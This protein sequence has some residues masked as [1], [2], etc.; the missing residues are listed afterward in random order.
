MK[1]KKVTI[2]E[3][4]VQVKK[5]MEEGGYSYNCI[6]LLYARYFRSI[7]IYYRKNGYVF[8]DPEV[9]E[10]YIKLQE[11]RQ[12]RGEIVAHYVHTIKL[13]A[14]R[15]NEYFLTGEI[16]ILNTERGSRYVVNE[17]NARLIDQFISWK[18]YGPN[19]SD[20]VIWVVRR[21]LYFFEKQ[22]HD[23]IDTVT[24]EEV[25]QYILKTAAEMKTSSLHNVLLYLKY[26]HIFLREEGIA[27][28]DCVDLLSY[29]VCREMPI[30]GYV[31][32]EELKAILDQVDLN[33]ARG[34]RDYAMI[35]LAATTGMRA[36]DIIRV[37][38][39][40]IDWRK[41]EIRFVQNKTGN[42]TYLPLIN[43][44]GKALQ[45]YILNARPS[46]ACPEIFLTNNP[47][48][49]AIMDASSVG[50]MFKRYQKKAGIRRTPFDGKGFHGLRRRLAKRLIES[51]TSLTTI[52]QILG[53]TD[54]QSARQYLSLDTR[55]L[56]ECALDFKG[57]EVKREG[58]S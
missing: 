43:E 5:A 37:K 6:H 58:L 13:A 18:N 10:A 1:E 47:P 11:D 31:T 23:S 8:Y 2:N 52:S 25:R 54:I 27:A 51:G 21:Y 35:N 38:L 42:T 15:L 48:L 55:N 33:T 3:L 32:D 41:G 7:E 20:D 44:T 28:P 12:E 53:H 22:G 57:I 36:C 16:R 14:R 34:K 29:K 49:R 50:D 24:V 9:T 46:S 26:F 56:K 19:T 4:I 39:G 45:D 30:Q 17:N 40:D